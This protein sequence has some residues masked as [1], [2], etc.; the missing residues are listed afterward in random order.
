MTSAS[1]M[2][3]VFPTT[4]ASSI[5]CSFYMTYAPNTTPVLPMTSPSYMTSATSINCSFT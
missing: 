2:N 3:T 5:T 1:V 4:S